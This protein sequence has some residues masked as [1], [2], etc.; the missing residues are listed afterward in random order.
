[1]YSRIG[2]GYEGESTAIGNHKELIK[3]SMRYYESACG[4]DEQ[5][6]CK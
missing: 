1:M 3:Q 2:M 6:E 5:V 4:H